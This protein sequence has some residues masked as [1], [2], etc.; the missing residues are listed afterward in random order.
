MRK[1]REYISSLVSV[2]FSSRLP[3]EIRSIAIASASAATIF[4]VFVQM[5]DKINSSYKD[6]L[7]SNQA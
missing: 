3:F 1:I 2:V 5:Q 6:G 7:P 4:F